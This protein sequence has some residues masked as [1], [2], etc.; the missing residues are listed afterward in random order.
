MQQSKKI[1]IIIGVSLLFLIYVYNNFFTTGMLVGTYANMNYKNS[2]ENP[3]VPDTLI[4]LPN[5]TFSSKYFGTGKYSLNY[6]MS[7]SK[8]NLI[9]DD[10]INQIN[11]HS[12]ITRINLNHPKITLCSDLNHY[13]EKIK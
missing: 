6:S 10:V 13:Y 2:T 12:N 9:F 7:G 8:I 4:L 1:I 5:N 3:S 11:I